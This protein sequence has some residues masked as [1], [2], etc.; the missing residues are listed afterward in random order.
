MRTSIKQ[1]LVASIGLALSFGVASAADKA[2]VQ[3]FSKSF[4]KVAAAELPAQAADAIAK[5]D[6][7]Q[8]EATTE[9]VV[10]AAVGLN[11]ASTPAIVGAIARVNPDMA[12][13]AARIAA[14][15][16]PKQAGAIARSAAAA[17]PEQAGKIVELVCR[18]VPGAYREIASVAAQVAPKA[19]NQIL[20]G[21]AA[22]IPVLRSSIA[23]AQTIAGAN[24]S[25]DAV[26][27]AATQVSATGGTT[28]S[29][30]RGPTIGGPYVPITTTP[31]NAPPG[32][33]TVPPGGR[34]YA[35]P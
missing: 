23:Q 28:T 13:L 11:P 2:L 32:G 17:A 16:Q 7:K 25:V 6:A 18:E 35:R 12:A 20:D 9:A 1:L 14:R 27:N 33:G 34:D 15:L 19:N 26:L 30:A 22:A 8:H 31:T 4:E 29:I 24:G 3:T 5:A 21:V 10:T